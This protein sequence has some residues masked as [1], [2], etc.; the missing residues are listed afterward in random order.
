MVPNGI[1]LKKHVGLIETSIGKMV[2]IMSEKD[3]KEDIL[4]DFAESYNTLILDKQAFKNSKPEVAG[5]A[6][7]ENIKAWVDRK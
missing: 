7:N 4:Q 3:I 2:L 6:A 5:L 1:Q